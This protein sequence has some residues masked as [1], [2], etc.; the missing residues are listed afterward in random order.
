VGTNFSTIVDF[1]H[2]GLTS[3]VT[4]NGVTPAAQPN[5]GTTQYNASTNPTF[6]VHCHNSRSPWINNSRSSTIT[7]NTLSGSTTVT[8]ASTS[9]LTLGMRVTGTGIP[10]G[11]TVTIKTIP[12][13][14][15]FTVSTAA[16]ATVTGTTLSVT[17]MSIAQASIGSHGG[18]TNGQ[19]C[20]SCHY[21]RGGE[22][23][24]PPTAGVFATG[25][26]SGN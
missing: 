15:T 10:T 14:T 24:T 6:C 4:I 3:N 1:N 13:A 5:L 7:A 8:T 12:S 2:D 16:N 18:S 22:R 21:V 17:H 11:V 23:L 25:S 9:A 19:D 26:I 20:T